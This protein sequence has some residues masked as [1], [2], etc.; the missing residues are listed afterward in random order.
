MGLRNLCALIGQA[1]EGVSTAASTLLQNVLTA[2]SGFH[3]HQEKL[4]K[5]EEQKRQGGRDPRPQFRM[6]KL[7]D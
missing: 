4:E 3:I 5:W 6:G 2:V 1:N 7:L